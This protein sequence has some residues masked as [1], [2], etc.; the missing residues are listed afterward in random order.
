MVRL[1]LAERVA[2]KRQG[3]LGLDR[4]GGMSKHYEYSF[5]SLFPA[6]SLY[7]IKERDTG[8]VYCLASAG[9]LPFQL[10]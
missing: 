3:I 7:K 8:E 2:M 6:R 1:P 4:R 9:E 10:I 5:Q